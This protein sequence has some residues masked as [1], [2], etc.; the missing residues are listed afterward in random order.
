MAQVLAHRTDTSDM[1]IPHGVFRRVLADAY[2]ILDGVSEGDTEHGAAVWS[3]FDNVLRFLDAHHD[4]EDTI[5]WPAL[6]ERCPEARSLITDMQTDHAAIHGLRERA[7][8]RL[9]LFGESLD[10]GAGRALAVSFASLLSELE[11]HLSREEEEILPLASANMSPEEW[12]ALPGHTMAQFTGDR[13]WLILGLILE[14]LSEREKDRVLAL[15]PPPAVE[16]WTTTGGTA[17]DDFMALV[18]KYR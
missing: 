3:Y 5:L 4:G 16:M 7:G 11:A 10:R 15:L 18:R 9:D 8:T 1:L 14:P 17:Y 13:I 12:G 6:L 2:V